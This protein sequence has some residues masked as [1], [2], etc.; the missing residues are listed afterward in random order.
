MPLGR[1]HR[2]CSK[3]I[4]RASLIAAVARHAGGPGGEDAGGE[5]IRSEYADDPDLAGV[6]DEFVAGLGDH[7]DAMQQALMA[8]AYDDLQREAH[9]L[10]G[11]GGSDGDPA[12]SEAAAAL[13]DA[14]KARDAE[15]ANLVLSNLGR[16]CQAV[17][18]ARGAKAGP[19][20]D[21]P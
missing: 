7:V 15:K 18:E 9:Q 19:K 10:K 6:I 21:H 14:A 16:L 8:S 12:M 5:T 17:A 11:A 13:E 3:P 1:L 20:E 4:D 2:F